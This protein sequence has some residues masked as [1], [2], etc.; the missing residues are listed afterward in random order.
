MLNAE[1]LRFRDEFVRHKALDAIGDLYVLGAPGDRPLRDPLRRPF[2]EQPAGP[3]PDGRPCRLADADLRAG[4]RR[5]DLARAPAARRAIGGD[6]VHTLEGPMARGHQPKRRSRLHEDV[7][8]VYRMQKGR[9]PVLFA[10]AAATVL[11]G[12]AHGRADKLAKADN[13]YQERPVELLYATGAERMDQHQWSAASSYFDEVERPAPLFGM[14]AARG[15]D[16]GLRPLRGQ[17][18]RRR[19]RRR[20]SLHLALSRQP[21]S[22]LR[23]LPEGAVLLRADRRRAAGP[24]LHPAGPRPPSA[25]CRSAIP[26][27]STPSTP[28]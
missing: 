25:R 10:A 8:K 4:A 1:P 15:A 12:C 20:R 5:S 23:L 9:A 3:R 11:A 13:A 16:G 14:G 6:R 7:F 26:P 18:V 22:L 2:L 24:G 17:P 27:P 28:G 21:V 19:H